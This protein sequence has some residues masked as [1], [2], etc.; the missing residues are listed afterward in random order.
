M[1]P[2]A[3]AGLA[4]WHSGLRGAPSG[5]GRGPEEIGGDGAAAV[6]VVVVPRGYTG[7]IALFALVSSPVVDEKGDDSSPPWTPS[8]QANQRTS[9]PRPPSYFSSGTEY[10]E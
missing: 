5:T 1:V 4:D 10:V 6:V 7:S 3:V 8:G 9:D 2:V